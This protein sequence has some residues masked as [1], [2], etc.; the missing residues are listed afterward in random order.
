MGK[1]GERCCLVEG[2]VGFFDFFFGV[3]QLLSSPVDF[4]YF[5]KRDL[6]LKKKS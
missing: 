2:R 4:A 1:L 6:V 3:A 5:R